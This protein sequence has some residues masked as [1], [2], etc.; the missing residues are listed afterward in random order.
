MGVWT[1]FFPISVPLPW[2]GH[3]GITDSEG[4]VHEFMGFGG[5][6]GYGLSFGPICRYYPLDENL[7]LISIDSGIDGAYAQMEGVGHGGCVNNCHSFVGWALDS[8]GYESCASWTMIEIAARLF[9]LGRFASFLMFC[10]WFLPAA[11][12]FYFFP[13]ALL[14]CV[15][16]PL[17]VLCIPNWIRRKLKGTV[18]R[19]DLERIS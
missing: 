6:H 7:A 13:K 3:I 15:C 16:L 2:L 1:P 11:V 9:F 19:G 12:F 18:D 5:S 14:Y 17:A 10:Y 4:E 8:M